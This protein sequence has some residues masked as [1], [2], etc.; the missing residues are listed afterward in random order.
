MRTPL[1]CAQCFASSLLKQHLLMHDHRR[2]RTGH[3]RQ[4]APGAWP[5]G[6]GRTSRV[7]ACC[8]PGQANWST[9]TGCPWSA[10]T[11][12]GAGVQLSFT[13]LEFEIDD[14]VSQCKHIAQSGCGSC[15]RAR[16]LG[17]HAWI[18][19][20]SWRAVDSGQGLFLHPCGR[21]CVGCYSSQRHAARYSACLEAKCGF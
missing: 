6:G 15:W 19:D 21:Q 3:L 11:C 17:A 4:M 5:R 2:W 13:T 14:R 20:L 7:T 18:R 1:S 8:W 16:V 9:T 10:W 12:L